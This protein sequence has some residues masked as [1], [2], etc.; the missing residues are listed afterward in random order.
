M[1]VRSG[2]AQREQMFSALNRPS[3][4]SRCSSNGE[5]SITVLPLGSGGRVSS[6]VALQ[7]GCHHE[8]SSIEYCH[9][10]LGRGVFPVGARRFLLP[11]GIYWRV[12]YRKFLLLDFHCTP[13]QPA[14]LNHSLL[15]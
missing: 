4:R 14:P 15:P 7:P 5:P 11:S 2:K 1:T 6:A 3:R 12:C 13:S 10:A 9:L 8:Q